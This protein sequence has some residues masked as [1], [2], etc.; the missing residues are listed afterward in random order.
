MSVAASAIGSPSE[1]V[2]ALR[3]LIAAD[4]FRP[5]A[6]RQLADHLDADGDREGAADA[7]AQHVRHAV[8]DPVLLSAATALHANDIPAA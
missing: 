5:Q 4:P 3:R 8:R 7:Y 1:A 2:A 6:W